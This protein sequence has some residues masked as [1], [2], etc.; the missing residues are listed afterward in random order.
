[1]FSLRLETK[2]EVEDFFN[3]FYNKLKF[4]ILPIDIKKYL[5]SEDRLPCYLFIYKDMYD[6]WR[7][8]EDFVSGK[9]AIDNRTTFLEKELKLYPL[10][11]LDKFRLA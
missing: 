10:I 7:I 2:E 3:I 9:M 4:K 8:K 6:N 1:M 11:I 5:L